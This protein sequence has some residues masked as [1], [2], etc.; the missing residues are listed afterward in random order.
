MKISIVLAAMTGNFE[1]DM[2][3]ASKTAQKRMKEIEKTAKQVGAAIGLALTA[4][5]T[6]AAVAIK[7]AINRADELSKTAQKIGVTTEALSALAYAA[8]ACGC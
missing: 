3:R 6:G 5:A 7:A 2:N 4:A 8:Q 1:T